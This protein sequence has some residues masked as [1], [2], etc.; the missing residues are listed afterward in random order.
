M[1]YKDGDEHG[2]EEN[3][4]GNGPEDD[5]AD[6]TMFVKFLGEVHV[7][8]SDKTNAE[9]RNNQVHDK[10]AVTLISGDRQE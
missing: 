7:E 4:N 6:R 8:V 5:T 9:R 1:D 10:S 2:E 3:Q